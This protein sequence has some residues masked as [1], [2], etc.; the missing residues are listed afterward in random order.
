[1]RP[2][3]LNILQNECFTDDSLV[4][5]AN[6]YYE[7]LNVLRLKLLKD[8]KKKKNVNNNSNNSLYSDM[9]KIIEESEEKS[10]SEKSYSEDMIPNDSNPSKSLESYS[11]DSS[12]TLK[13]SSDSDSDGKKIKIKNSLLDSSSPS[14]SSS[15]NSR[16]PKNRSFQYNKYEFP[17]I[18]LNNNSIIT[19]KKI[20][21]PHKAKS[22]NNFSQIANRL[23]MINNQISD[24]EN[25][26]MKS[27]DDYNKPKEEDNIEKLKS[28]SQLN[29]MLKLASELSNKNQNG[30]S[31]IS[32]VDLM[33]I[34]KITV[35]KKIEEKKDLKEEIMKLR[36]ENEELN[37]RSKYR[38]T[39][40]LRRL[41]KVR[42][43][44]SPEIKSSKQ[45]NPYLKPKF[46]LTQINAQRSMVNKNNNFNFIN[47]NSIEDSKNLNSLN[48]SSF[49]QSMKQSDNSP[50][51]IIFQEEHNDENN[52]NSN[53][54]QNSE[55]N[56]LQILNHLRDKNKQSKLNNKIISIQA[57]FFLFLY[58]QY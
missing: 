42:N 2:K 30:S 18:F 5:Y 35:K 39:K 16:N 53:I 50:T 13:S 21:V 20:F 46:P 55:L 45:L 43:I 52:Y 51:N 33:A 25:N 9:N 36:N 3:C 28:Q 27:P 11:K 1:M 44:F 17:K 34:P 57:N 49:I 37:N 56:S 15:E 38:E 54:H 24:W 6:L 58:T 12:V 26:Q 10:C 8:K 14:I 40:L 4:D 29:G 48:K 31:E 23:G 22:F 19:K 41:T 7:H 32:L 47:Y